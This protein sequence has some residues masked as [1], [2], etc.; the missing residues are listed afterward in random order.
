M[1]I[2]FQASGEAASGVHPH[3]VFEALL[4]G[5]CS[6]GARSGLATKKDCF[7]FRADWQKKPAP[8]VGNL[9]QQMLGDL[10]GFEEALKYSG[11]QSGF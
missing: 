5:F 7:L 10:E 3:D 11:L 8:S 4:Q 2:C 6:C 9:L 1:E